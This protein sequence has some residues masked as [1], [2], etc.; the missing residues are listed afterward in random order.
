MIKF[1][2][3][4]TLIELLVVVAIIGILAAVGVTQFSGFSESSKAKVVQSQHSNVVKFMAA[5]FLKCQNDPNGGFGIKSNPHGSG[6]AMGT[7]IPAT[8][9]IDCKEITTERMGYV[10]ESYFNDEANFKN[11]YNSDLAGVDYSM[12][13]GFVLGTVKFSVS[14]KTFRVIS[15]W[16]DENGQTKTLISTVTDER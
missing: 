13:P 6:P 3:G 8:G 2:K 4:F 5:Q 12:G 1:K 14:G 16:R 10:F 9:M 11:P 7:A 15:A